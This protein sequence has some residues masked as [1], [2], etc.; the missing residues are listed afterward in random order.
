MN[1]NHEN[2][3]QRRELSLNWDVFVTPAT[4]LVAKETA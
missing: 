1:I 3:N 4:D 2:H